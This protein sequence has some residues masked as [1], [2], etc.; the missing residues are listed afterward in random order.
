MIRQCLAGTS[1]M[2]TTENRAVD[3]RVAA[4]TGVT[5]E[6]QYALI[7]ALRYKERGTSQGTEE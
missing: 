3:A 6:A 7:L 4:D 2:G 5:S 1:E